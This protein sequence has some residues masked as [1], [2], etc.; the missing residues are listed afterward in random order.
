MTL[1]TQPQFS[2]RFNQPASILISMLLVFAGAALSGCGGEE[3]KP[4][5]VKK[6]TRTAAPAPVQAR[7]LQE[8]RAEHG[9]DQRV[10]MQESDAPSSEMEKIAVLKFFDAWVRGDH[11]YVG[12]VVGLADQAQ[13]LAMVKDGQWDGVT[14]DAIEIVTLQTGPAQDGGACVLAIFESTDVMQTGEAQLWRYRDN[15][16]EISFEA[17]AAPPGM[18]DRLSGADPIAEWWKILNE[19]EA[20]W[21]L[22]D[23]DQLAD[24][25]DDEDEEEASSK[26][27][28][29]SGGSGR[30]QPGGGRRV[31]GGR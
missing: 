31:P 7:T 6:Q 28:K 27:N 15:G 22:D 12:S 10:E 29:S 17:V 18:V 11:E 21:A 1:L 30:R 23:S 2:R 3:E 16:G 14:G 13:L 20:M 24:L 8:I 25:D 19:E 4:K 9:I 5:T 26:S